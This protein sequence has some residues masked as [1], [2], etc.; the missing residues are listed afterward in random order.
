MESLAENQHAQG[1]SPQENER[2]DAMAATDIAVLIAAGVPG[3]VARYLLVA[4]NVTVAYRYR[5]YDP[6]R[7]STHRHVDGLYFD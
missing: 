3:A 7:H 2:R 5:V 4:L 1:P 6:S